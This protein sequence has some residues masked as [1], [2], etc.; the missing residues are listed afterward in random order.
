MSVHLL[1]AFVLAVQDFL[2]DHFLLLRVHHGT[3]RGLVGGVQLQIPR[4]LSSCLVSNVN[5]QKCDV[6]FTSGRSLVL[7]GFGLM[8][9]ALLDFIA[10]F[11]A[12]LVILL[13]PFQGSYLLWVLLLE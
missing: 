12:C 4:E 8:L 13:S 5:T 9:L 2:P 10:S 3:D 1:K 11:I 7:Y 6:T